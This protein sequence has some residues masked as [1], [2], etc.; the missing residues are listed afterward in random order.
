LLANADTIHI[1]RRLWTDPVLRSAVVE[2]AKTRAQKPRPSVSVEYL[3][4]NDPTKPT[5]TRNEGNT[6]SDQ[7]RALLGQLLGWRGSLK[8]NTGQDWFER[9]FGW[10]LTVLAL[11]LGAPFWFDLLNKFVNIRS[12]GKSPDEI[13]KTPAKQE[14]PVRA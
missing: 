12:N 8:D 4:E 14:S 11:S 1:A 2:E 5:V 9:V 3:D 7:E 6:L 10:L 13:A